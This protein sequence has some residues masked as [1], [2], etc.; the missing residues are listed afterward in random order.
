[1]HSA[2]NHSSQPPSFCHTIYTGPSSLDQANLDTFELEK[3]LRNTYSFLWGYPNK[4]KMHGI[5]L[6]DK[7]VRDGTAG[8]A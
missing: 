4:P 1:M 3:E 2:T 5:F 8:R 6:D 7:R